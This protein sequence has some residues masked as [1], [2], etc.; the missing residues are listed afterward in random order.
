ML[1]TIT[2]REGGLDAAQIGVLDLSTGVR[3]TLVKGG[4]HGRYVDSGHLVY[5][6]GGS[7]HAAAFDLGRLELLGPA[8][9]VLPEV[10]TTGEGGG[11]LTIAKNGTAVYITRPE[12]AERELVWVDRSGREETV[13]APLRAYAAPRVSPDA[14]AWRCA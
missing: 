9:P 4:T 3:K 10:F 2:A 14:P 8:R 12:D 11:N 1:F 7:A 13:G 5:M 6:S